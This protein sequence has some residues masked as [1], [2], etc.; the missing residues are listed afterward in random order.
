MR[1]NKKANFM[2]FSIILDV[3]IIMLSFVMSLWLRISV[4]ARI[5][6]VSENYDLVLQPQS[7]FAAFC[8]ALVIIILYSFLNLY[9]PNYKS[10]TWQEFFAILCV[11]GLGVITIGAIL[12]VFRLVEFTRLGLAF[13]YIISCVFVFVKR[14]LLY[15]RQIKRRENGLEPWNVILVG[16]GE[17]AFRYYNNVI[18]DKHFGCVF[19]GYYAPECKDENLLPKSEYKGDIDAVREALMNE[20]IDELIIAM[21]QASEEIIGKLVSA[22]GR[23]GVKVSVIQVYNDFIP[24]VPR[25][26]VQGNL[27]LMAV[28]SAPN[29]GIVWDIVK[30][31]MD[32]V[33]SFIGIVL[34]WPIMLITAISI[35][36]NSKGEIIFKQPRVGKNGKIFNMYK[37]RSMYKD[38]ESRLAELQS[39]NESDGPTFK[40]AKDPR[41]TSVG[42]F[43]RKTSIDELPQLFNILKGEMSI[44]GPRPP[45]QREVDQY[46]DW[47]WGRLTVKPGLTCYWQIS[48]RSDISFSQWMSLDLQYVEE[49]GFL[50]DIKIILKTVI[51]VFTGKGAY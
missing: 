36:L 2:F 38:A 19:K 50:T 44:V 41:I 35:K 25:V 3:F 49:Q 23:F 26:E 33:L 9:N 11:N 5:E 30:R 43:I 15:K 21:P 10:G 34:L 18:K 42:S 39:Q 13:F 7:M 22:G 29:K 45:L 1:K 51:V 28:R 16:W 31:S 6:G 24:A 14:V 17:L 12:Y 8:A 47:D 48:G 37:F 27:K 40:I 4:V 32:V 20:E 46:S